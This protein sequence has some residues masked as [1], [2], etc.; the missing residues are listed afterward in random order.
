MI[1]NRIIGGLAS[2][3]RRRESTL[4]FASLSD[5]Q[6]RDIGVTRYDLFAPRRTR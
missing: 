6:L 2:Y 3:R 4:E 5:H 1:I